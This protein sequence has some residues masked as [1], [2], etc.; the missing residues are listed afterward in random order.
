[1]KRWGESS[2][3]LC[4]V[5]GSSNGSI[6]KAVTSDQVF[7][8]FCSWLSHIVILCVA[9]FQNKIERQQW[10]VSSTIHMLGESSHNLL[11]QGICRVD[12]ILFNCG[13]MWISEFLYNVS[14]D[15]MN[16]STN[17]AYFCFTDVV[18]CLLWDTSQCVRLLESI[19]LIMD[20]ILLIFQ[21]KMKIWFS[22]LFYLFSQS[23]WKVQTAVSLSTSDGGLLNVCNTVD[24]TETLCF[25]IASDKPSKHRAV[26]LFMW[27][28]WYSKWPLIR[29]GISFRKHL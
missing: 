22:D 4:K 16:V 19:S 10:S 2:E 25:S 18:L 23:G 26:R 5:Y 8:C 13:A 14:F 1:M 29:I 3:E 21:G 15:G 20:N 6:K 12:L 28:F 27:H 9:I 17:P 11:D 7:Q 24:V